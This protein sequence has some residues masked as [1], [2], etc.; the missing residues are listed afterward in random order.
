MTSEP[1]RSAYVGFIAPPI[2]DVLRA[3]D[4]PLLLAKHDGCLMFTDAGFEDASA[5]FPSARTVTVSQPPSADE[6]FAR[7]LREFCLGVEQ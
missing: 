4:C 3:I 2:G 6:E 1:E 7:A 5:A